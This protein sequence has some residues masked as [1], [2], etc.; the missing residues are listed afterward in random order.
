MRAVLALALIAVFSVASCQKDD[1]PSDAI[2]DPSQDPS[3]DAF[4]DI[5]PDQALPE[6]T[7][8]EVEIDTFVPE[9]VEMEVVDL[10][11]RV[12]PTVG[13]SGEGNV[14]IGAS[15]PRGMVK[16]GP[17][18]RID[19][20]GVSGYS[21]NSDTI[22]GFVHSHLEGPGGSGNGYNRILVMP[23]T[24][25][26]EPNLT[27][28]TSTFSHDNEVAK[29]HLYQVRL[30]T[31]GIDV[32]VT[33]SRLVGLHRWTFP[34]AEN[35][36]MVLDLVS[37]LG[38]WQEAEMKVVS[39]TLV[40]G[41]SRYQTNPLVAIVADMVDPGTGI[42]TV[43]YSIK[44]DR[45]FTVTK[46]NPKRDTGAFLSFSTEDGDVVEARVGISY[47]SVEQA[48]LN[49]EVI[50]DKTFEQVQA[51]TKHQWNRLLSRVRVESD[52]D[53]DID[54]LYTAVYHSLLAPA[55][56]TEGT[57]FFSGADGKG[58]T[59]QT[60][61]WRYYTDDWCMWDTYRTS[62]PWF[63]LIEPEVNSDIAQSIVHTYE[64]GGWMQKC[65]WNAVGDSRVMT[66]NPQFCIIANSFLRGFDKFNIDT[67]WEGM[68]KG[69]MEDSENPAPDGMC[70]YF[71]RGTPPDYVERGFVSMDCDVDQSAS[72]TLEHAHNDWCVARF[73]EKQNKKDW[74]DF[75]YKRSKNYANHFNDEYGFMVPKY[76]DGS[77]LKNFSPT[78]PDGFCEADSW[79]YTWSVPHDICGLVDLIGGNDK[80]EAKLDEFFSD[81]H[82]DVTNQP[83]FHV[84]W[85]YS[86]IGKASKTQDLV[87]KLVGNHFHLE[88]NGLPGN[89]DAGSTSAWLI[90][91]LL[92]FYPVTPGGDTYIMNAP[93][94][95]RI[96]LYIDPDG[97]SRKFEIIANNYTAENRFI[98][99]AVLDGEPLDVPELEHAIIARGGKL[100]LE[101]GPNPSEWGRAI[102]Y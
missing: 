26:P 53:E 80:F 46:F 72:M 60:Q 74:A 31:Y 49:R 62:H 48:R 77:W 17:N 36:G 35:A 25:T 42:S 50:T 52:S 40:E 11:D 44:L 28:W 73:A 91:A 14:F 96:E 67:A 81:G 15:W 58:Q 68:L 7:G 2:Q 75:F 20:G 8:E 65:T 88:S 29:P 24:G 97:T 30:D 21:Y 43:Y 94:F 89:D 87:A 95:K 66:A 22:Q 79:K 38:A 13:T 93:Q 27:G 39:D 6:D 61:G 82:F 55:D 92:G 1:D 34:A 3:Q 71:N 51:E 86:F 19:S 16:V 85:L 33:A 23:F 98:Q 41:F 78:S 9:I 18:N 101:M 90:F 45:S 83:D 70:G 10:V 56:Y 57:G 99:S 5:D 4:Q 32:E 76:R 102:C 47:I 59:Y 12:R 100:V 63:T 84:P 64:A 69:S 54:R 37:S